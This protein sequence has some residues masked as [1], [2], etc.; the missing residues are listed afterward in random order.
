MWLSY[1]F[2]K[3]YK[4]YFFPRTVFHWNNLPPYIVT[5]HTLNQFNMAVGH[6]DH[7]SPFYMFTFNNPL[8]FITFIC[9]NS[10]FYFFI[11]LDAPTVYVLEIG[12]AVMEDKYIDIPALLFG[13]LLFYIKQDKLWYYRHSLKT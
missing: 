13:H 3:I 4:Q 8:Y 12:L 10:S 2:S 1:K 9:Q 7:I 6:I 11:H 5:L